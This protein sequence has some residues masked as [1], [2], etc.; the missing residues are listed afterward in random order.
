MYWPTAACG[1]DNS[2]SRNFPML[3]TQ[4]LRIASLGDAADCRTYMLPGTDVNIKLRKLFRS[5]RS[6]SC[7]RSIV[8][9]KKSSPYTVSS[10]TFL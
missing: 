5:L 10:F 2:N 7:D 8:P 1:A 6:L 9:Y 3:Q 4:N